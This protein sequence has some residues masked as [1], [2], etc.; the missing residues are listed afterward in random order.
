MFLTVAALRIK[1]GNCDLRQS[2]LI[3]ILGSVVHECREKLYTHISSIWPKSIYS[4]RKSLNI[5]HS[6]ECRRIMM[7]MESP[8]RTQ[9]FLELLKRGK[10]CPPRANRLPETLPEV[11]WRSVCHSAL[12]ARG[13]AFRCDSE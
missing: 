10:A 7:M 1:L 4:I 9:L 12:Q 3:Q 5:V 6:I 13:W 2:G 8:N 11:P